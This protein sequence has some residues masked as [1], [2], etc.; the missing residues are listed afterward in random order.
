MR[1]GFLSK[2][3]TP[4][5]T[6]APP[7]EVPKVEKEKLEVTREAYTR[8]KISNHCR[9][10]TSHLASVKP[11]PP[12]IAHH[13]T[14][15]NDALPALEHKTNNISQLKYDFTLAK[16]KTISI[17][18]RAVSPTAVALIGFI[19]GDCSGKNFVPRLVSIGGAHTST[20]GEVRKNVIQWQQFCNMW[21]K[22]ADMTMAVEKMVVDRLQ[23][24]KLA[25]HAD[26]YKPHGCTV[27]QDKLNE[28]VDNNRLSIK[29]F[30]CCWLFD[31]H[32]ISTKRNAN[33]LN[34]NYINLIKSY[35]NM[36]IWENVD[37]TRYHDFMR[38][39]AESFNTGD[40]IPKGSNWHPVGAIQKIRPVSYAEMTRVDDINMDLWRE[41]YVMS[42]CSELVVNFVSQSFS[43]IGNWFFISSAHAQLFDS[44]AIKE[45]YTQSDIANKVAEQLQR[46]DEYNA[47]ATGP[48]ADLVN[49]VHE[50]IALAD[51]EVRLTQQAV[52]IISE[53]GGRTIINAYEV[54]DTKNANSNI[55][56]TFSDHVYF[57]K[58]AFEFLHACASLH[59]QGIAHGDL[60]ASKVVFQTQLY[61]YDHEKRKELFN[62]PLCVFEH[63]DTYLFPEDGSHFMIISMASAIMEQTARL[64]T[65]HGVNFVERY[66]SDQ[67]PRAARQLKRVIG[68]KFNEAEFAKMYN[69]NIH[70]AFLACAAADIYHFFNTFLVAV[71]ESPRK[72]PKESVDL[73]HK[74][75]DR[76]FEMFFKPV[77]KPAT[78]IIK[79]L[80]T[81]FRIG[82]DYPVPANALIFNVFRRDLP[83]TWNLE[84]YDSW[85]PLI[86]REEEFK[87]YQKIFKKPRPD[88]ATWHKFMQMDE[89]ARLNE[90]ARKYVESEAGIIDPVP[91]T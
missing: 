79:E 52:C 33:N 14:N 27:E 4:E 18:I 41:I 80:F 35:N 70:N 38:V 57:A 23:K 78:V 37:Q 13:I 91:F 86:N 85:G 81:A 49:T 83:L 31:F 64:N 2:K 51:K 9:A 11:I 19:H 12:V 53:W 29:F 82:P 40:V 72:L 48:V 46:A 22:F 3:H 50:A 39:C 77:E 15:C 36:E 56:R 89:T 65:D 59:M 10:Y 74:I 54:S 62:N 20:H 75:R 24:T 55:I 42:R 25:F 17:T 28:F 73:C 21:E 76:A 47:N 67:L 32:L 5:V 87:L 16:S 8:E 68:D 66:L 44:P 71:E 84:D 45:K 30:V 88:Q 6:A 43:C 63:E 90:I 7:K 26:F 69:E 60:S 61:T 34:S 58:H 1:K